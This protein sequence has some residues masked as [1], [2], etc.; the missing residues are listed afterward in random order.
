[1]KEEKPSVQEI[2]ELL[3]I[4]PSTMQAFKENGNDIETGNMNA[5]STHRTKSCGSCA[6]VCLLAI[7]RKY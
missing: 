5:A 3:N 4:P 6:Y 7:Q 2:L 1:M